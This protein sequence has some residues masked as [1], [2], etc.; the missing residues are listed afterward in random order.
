MM[1]NLP[2]TIFLNVD[3]EDEGLC[4][5]FKDLEG[6]TWTKNK[7]FDTDV[8]YIRYDIVK[9]MIKQFAKNKGVEI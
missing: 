3:P 5:E 6:V 4:N 2:D 1:K 7:E 9:E 8:E